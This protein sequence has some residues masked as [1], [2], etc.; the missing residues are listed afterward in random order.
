MKPLMPGPT[1]LEYSK[2]V[3]LY[4][5]AAEGW[6]GVGGSPKG[7]MQ[8]YMIYIGIQR[9]ISPYFLVYVCTILILGLFRGR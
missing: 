8:R 9:G 2:A 5:L 4:H 6:A 3:G 1:D 7:S